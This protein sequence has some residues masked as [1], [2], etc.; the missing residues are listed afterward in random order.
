MWMGF[1]FP[2]SV[3]DGS[4]RAVC[5]SGFRAS[6]CVRVRDGVTFRVAGGVSEVGILC[7]FGYIGSGGFPGRVPRLGGCGGGF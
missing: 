5:M 4:V 7:F 1:S 3:L 2:L 6:V